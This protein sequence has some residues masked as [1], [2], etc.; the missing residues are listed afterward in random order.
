MSGVQ[1]LVVLTLIVLGAATASAQE[2]QRASSADALEKRVQAALREA[3]I[4]SADRIRVEAQ[5][6]ALQL[7][8]FV[9]SEDDLEKALETARSVRGVATVRND[10]LVREDRPTIGQAV[11]DTVIAARVRD[12]IES[13]VADNSEI[14]V[15]V[16]DGIVQ[17][18]GYVENA[19]TKNRAAD[20][21]SA[22]FGVQDVRN[23]IA[24]KQ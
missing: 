13:T 5:D 21:A 17:L 9:E 16:S 6:G 3:H 14:H 12:E 11:D 18:S 22:V 10:L 1:R 15:A 4:A 19:D 23:H 24:L 20:V 2:R 7:S 8:G